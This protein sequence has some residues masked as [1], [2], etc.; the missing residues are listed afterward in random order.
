MEAKVFN[1]FKVCEITASFCAEED[2]P[3]PVYKGATFRGAFGYAF[4]KAIC[5]SR[6]TKSCSECILR[7][8]CVYSYVFETPL[9]ENALI[10]RKYEKI[11]HPFILRPP[12]DDRPA[13]KKG[14]EFNLGAVLIGKAVEYVP[15]FAFVMEAMGEM[16]LG[17]KKAKAR[18]TEVRDTSKV[19]YRPGY[20]DINVWDVLSMP[21]VLAEGLPMEIGI[22]FIT[23]ARLVKDHKIVRPNSLDFQTLFRTLLRRVALLGQ[24]HCGIPADSIDFKG[25]IDMSASIETVENKL[26]WYDWSRYSTRQKARMPAGG[27]KGRIIFKGNIKPFWP[28]LALGQRLNVGKNT[29]FGLGQ[30]K[31]TS[32]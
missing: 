8:G 4:K 16:G 1:N 27:L 21:D 11:P 9:P 2:I 26:Y 28:Y 7:R 31:I 13:I 32:L 23:P 24:F 25:I 20:T 22:D 5:V 6:F 3:L 18:L 10:M 12:L 14:E 19:I 15:Y 29:S 30:Y 17:A